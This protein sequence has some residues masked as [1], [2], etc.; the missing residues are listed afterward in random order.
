MVIC[1]TPVRTFDNEGDQKVTNA[2]IP[3]VTLTSVEFD[4][5]EGR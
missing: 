5:E 1:S 2:N 4:V 3:S